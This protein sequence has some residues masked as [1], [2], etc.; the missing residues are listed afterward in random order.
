MPDMPHQDDAAA[1]PIL[2]SVLQAPE[3]SAGARRRANHRR[4]RRVRSGRKRLE[5]AAILRSAP[6]VRAD[7]MW[8]F[9]LAFAAVLYSAV[10]AG[11]YFAQTWL[12]FPAT[13]VA[14]QIPLPA[15]AQRL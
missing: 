15:S 13:L 14:G 5:S 3:W 8:L 2:R 10:I 12:L 6:H 9:L 1:R 4:K 7:P 11:M